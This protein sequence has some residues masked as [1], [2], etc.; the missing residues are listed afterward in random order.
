MGSGRGNGPGGRAKKWRGALTTDER[1]VSAGELAELMGV[2][3]CAP[4]SA[5]PRRHAVRDL[6]DARPALPAVGQA[7]AWARAPRYVTA[8][9]QPGRRANAAGHNRR[10]SPMPTQLPSGRWR[11]RIRHPRTGEQLNPR[12]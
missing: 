9:N 10:D 4:S 3:A 6:G 12:P 8:A 11:P 7:I 1:Y 2:S 5:G